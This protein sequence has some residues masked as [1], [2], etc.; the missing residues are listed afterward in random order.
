MNLMDSVPATQ[1][2]H[3]IIMKAAL[4]GMSVRGHLSVPIKLYLKKTTCGSS[5]RGAVVNE[6]D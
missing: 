1:L 2:C 4:G 6:F 3:D 5:R